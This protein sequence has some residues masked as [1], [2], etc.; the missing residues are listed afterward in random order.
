MKF[1]CKEMLMAAS[2]YVQILPA[3]LDV[4]IAVSLNISI[5][6]EETREFI[7]VAKAMFIKFIESHMLD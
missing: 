1:S 6:Q 7:S 3:I 2:W 4:R 5:L